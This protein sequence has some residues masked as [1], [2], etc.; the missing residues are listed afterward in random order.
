MD[1]MPSEVG[2]RF[3][4]GPKESLDTP[5]PEVLR[6]GTWDLPVVEPTLPRK[7]VVDA[8]SP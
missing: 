3:G 4:S 6:R 7:S 1:S 8:G 5:T 2:L